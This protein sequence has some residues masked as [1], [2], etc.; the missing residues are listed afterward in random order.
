M[1]FGN[2]A[3]L[4]LGSN[5]GDRTHF[6]EQA[7]WEISTLPEI[8][9]ISQS[10]R[11]ETAPLENINQ[12]FFLNQILKIH[13]SPS[14]TLPC[15]LDTLQA[16]EDKLGRKRRSWKGPREIDIDIL[17]YEAVVMET[18]FLHLPHHSLFT[19]P[20]IRQLLFEMGESEVYSLFEESIYEKYHSRV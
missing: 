12:P 4:S 18:E 7:V 13:V 6:L 19:R 17:T 1:K 16:I 14:F 8:R 3:F 10:Q 5:I 9:I 20:F 15:L 11:L 2:I